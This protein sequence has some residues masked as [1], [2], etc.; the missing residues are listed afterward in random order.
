M[1]ALVTTELVETKESSQG[2]YTMREAYASIS[3]KDLWEGKKPK[4]LERTEIVHKS[5]Y[6]AGRGGT[7]DI[8]F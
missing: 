2:L 7:L 5:P 1:H 4:M 3:E 6:E 8:G